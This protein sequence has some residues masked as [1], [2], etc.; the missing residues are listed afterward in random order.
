MAQIPIHSQER[1]R[2][3]RVPL[4]TAISYRNYDSQG[5]IKNAINQN[6]ST[7][8]LHLLS[9]SPLRT[10]ERVDLW[11]LDPETD[12]LINLEGE[13]VWVAIDD[14]YGDSPY[15]VRAG[16]RFT[17]GETEQVDLLRGLVKK[18]GAAIAG[19]AQRKKQP[20]ISFAI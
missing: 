3:L 10:E 20:R 19:T 11:I 4:R 14:L 16:V 1:R 13:V 17:Y 9:A 6:I 12:R 18:R 8:G 15:W 5:K 2:E 7:T